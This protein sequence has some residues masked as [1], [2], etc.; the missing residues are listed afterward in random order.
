MKDVRTL[1]SVQM[2]LNIS[3]VLRRSKRAQ[4][5]PELLSTYESTIAIL[6]FGTPH[7]GS[8]VADLG[9]VVER[10]VSSV[11]E[12]SPRL[13]RTLQIDSAE[14]DDLREEFGIM[15]RDRGFMVFSFQEEKAMNI[16]LKGYV[17]VNVS[18]HYFRHSCLIRF[19]GR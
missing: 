19:Q 13:L 14:L 16:P 12:T 5:T 2:E 6:F 3:Q 7:R 11:F 8:S 18:A 17:K 4:H 9:L 10:L 1:I 15:H